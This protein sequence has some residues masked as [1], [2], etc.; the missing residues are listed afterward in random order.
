MSS[1]VVADETAIALSEVGH[2]SD[3]SSDT[4]QPNCFY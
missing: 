2:A 1:I 4:E 3:A